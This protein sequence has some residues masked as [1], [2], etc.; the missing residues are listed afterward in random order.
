LEPYC[1]YRNRSGKAADA[2]ALVIWPMRSALINY[3]AVVSK[4]VAK[5]GVI[6]NNV[7][8]GMIAPRHV[9]SRERMG[10]RSKYTP[11]RI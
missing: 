1:Q 6:I 3:T 4:Q 10:R 11:R 9:Y 5:H 2:N 7:L 8:P